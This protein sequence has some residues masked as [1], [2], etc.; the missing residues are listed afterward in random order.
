MR[1]SDSP[2]PIPP[3]SVASLGGTTLSLWRREGLPGSWRTPPCTCP[4]LRPRQDLHVRPWA[5]IRAVGDSECFVARDYRRPCLLPP[6]ISNPSTCRCC[7]PHISKRR[8]PQRVI[9]GLNHTACTLAVYAPQRELPHHHVRLAS[10]WWPALVGRDW[11]PAGS[12]YKVSVPILTTSSLTRLS[13]RTICKLSYESC[14]SLPSNDHDKIELRA[15]ARQFLDTLKSCLAS[16]RQ[17]GYLV[18]PRCFCVASAM[19]GRPLASHSGGPGGSKMKAG[20]PSY[21]A[22]VR[23]FK[24]TRACA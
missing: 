19:P 23:A 6:P 1:H 22:S 2:S 7:L 13:W 20:G 5:L 18:R 4:A 24:A 8:L 3:R 21:A 17:G 14:R 15:T 16:A 12:H 11:L 10:D 9:S